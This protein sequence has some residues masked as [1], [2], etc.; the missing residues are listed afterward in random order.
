[1]GSRGD[2]ITGVTR[3]DIP[4]ER[5]AEVL[6]FQRGLWSAEGLQPSRVLWSEDGEHPGIRIA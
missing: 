5:M 1:M 4:L 2:R 3:D 6:D